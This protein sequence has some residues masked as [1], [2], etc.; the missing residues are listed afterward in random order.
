M[1]L[2]LNNVIFRRDDIALVI[3]MFCILA[4]TVAVVVLKVKCTRNG[5]HMKPQEKTLTPKYIILYTDQTQSV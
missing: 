2:I 1:F 4:V 3:G 5:I